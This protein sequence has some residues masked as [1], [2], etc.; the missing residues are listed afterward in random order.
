VLDRDQQFVGAYTTSVERPGDVR[1]LGLNYRIPLYAQAGVL[2]LSHTRSDV[3]GSFGTFNSSGAG[4]TLGLT[5]SHYLPPVGGY[6]SYLSAGVDDKVFDATLI[7]GTALVGQSPRRSRPLSLG[8]SAARESDTSVWGYTAEVL[9][10][11]PGGGGNSLADYRSEDP[12]ITQNRWKLL[13]GSANYSAAVARG[14]NWSART[15]F[16]F[17]GDALISGEQ[18][19]L[20]G[21][22]SVRGTEERPLSGDKG[23]T[24][25]LEL[26][27]PQWSGLRGI[28]FLDSGWLANVVS[29]GSSKPASDHVASLGMGLRYAS[30]HVSVVADWGHVVQGSG[31]PLLVNTSSPK[32]G[33][34]KLHVNVTTRF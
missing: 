14:W 32:S 27:S 22:A 4:Q 2:S 9:I 26:S 21:T 31:V 13:R 3:V 34:E 30:R 17:S 19:G 29:N 12:R 24:F 28:F 7:N 20:G 23:L 16:Q 5:Y 10:N 1:Q 15:Q 33:D 25:A 18:L 6:R 11:L 8:Y